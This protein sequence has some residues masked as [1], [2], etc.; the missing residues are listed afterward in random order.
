[1]T[2][3]VADHPTLTNRI[4]VE[5]QTITISEHKQRI[6]EI[7]KRCYDSILGTDIPEVKLENLIA[8]IKTEEGIEE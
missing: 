8:K 5:K 4:E 6:K 1:M 3:I 7:L 2:N